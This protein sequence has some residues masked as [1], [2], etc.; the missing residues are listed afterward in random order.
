ML[1]FIAAI[2]KALGKKAKKEF[3][4]MQSGDVKA[5]LADTSLMKSLAVTKSFTSVQEGVGEFVTWYRD[6]YRV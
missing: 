5:T 3:L 6:Y 4:V 1:D 2:E